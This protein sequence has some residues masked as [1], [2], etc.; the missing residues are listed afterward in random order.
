MRENQTGAKYWQFNVW[1]VLQGADETGEARTRIKI[2][3]AAQSAA[4][5]A[6]VALVSRSASVKREGAMSRVKQHEMNQSGRS[7]SDG[8]K[9]KSPHL[10]CLNGKRRP[11]EYLAKQ[12]RA[13]KALIAR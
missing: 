11:E 8:G 10:V 9:Q 7:R 5:T 2:E 1:L 4:I 12:Q 6:Q 3:A 13:L